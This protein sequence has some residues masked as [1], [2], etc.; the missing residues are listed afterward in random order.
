MDS[1][2]TPPLVPLQKT[3]TTFADAFIASDNNFN[4]IRMIAASIVLFSHCFLA[5]GIPNREPF[6]KL[7]NYD[8]GGGWGVSIF[9]V[10][11]GFL[12]TRS[13]L[14]HGTFDY[15]LSRII[16]IVPALALV[17][18]V[19]VFLIGPL[20][21]TETT[22]EYFL[23]RQTWRYLLNID[24]FDLTYNLPGVF[25]SNPHAG[26][27]NVSLWTLPLECGFYI[28]LPLMVAVGALKPRASL[29]APFVLIIVYS[30]IVFYFHM[31]WNNGGGV[32]FRGAPLYPTVRY[33][34]FFLIGSCCWIWR[35]KI[36][37][38]HSFALLMLG[39]LYLFASQPFRIAAYYV[40]LP[41]LVMYA[42]FTKIW[43]LDKY[44]KIGDYS[45]GT[46]IFAFPV[47]QSIVATMGTSMGPLML[48][49]FAAPITFCLAFLSWRFVEHPAL[50]LRRQLFRQE[51]FRGVPGHDQRQR[52]NIR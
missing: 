25:M 23:S 4:L 39:I 1:I 45:Y 30:V 43:L 20:E 9:F 40:A 19:T 36:V 35:D 22:S 6:I 49:A 5:T 2:A 50:Q 42:A 38:S 13:V 37:Y 51:E 15:L 16:R 26:I 17:T 27:V 44:Q 11:S 33:S 8:A 46:Y 12:V 32:L 47:Q 29:V 41:Y 7:G 21:T 34:L 52:L 10:I 14:S 31:D 48:C 3:S 18:I 24:V 28:F